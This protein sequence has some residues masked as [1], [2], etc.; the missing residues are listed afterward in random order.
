MEILES[1]KGRLTI[2]DDSD[3]FPSFYCVHYFECCYHSF[4]F[5]LEEEAPSACGVALDW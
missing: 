3:F 4:Y 5:G 1:L 2:G